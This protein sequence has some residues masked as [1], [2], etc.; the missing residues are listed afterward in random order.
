[1]QTLAETGAGGLFV[2]YVLLTWPKK[3]RL[4]TTTPR[5]PIRL[6]HRDKNGILDQML[7]EDLHE[8]A[9]KARCFSAVL[10]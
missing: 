1:M 9:H 7:E 2:K 10:A 8:D 3:P 6:T 4:F 5:M